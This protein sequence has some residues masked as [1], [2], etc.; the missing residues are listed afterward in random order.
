MADRLT[1]DVDAREVLQALDRLSVA[2]ERALKR[3]AR[4]TADAIARE[5]RARAR[6]ATGRLAEAITVE[7]IASGYRVFVSP[8]QDPAGG[9]RADNFGLWHEH[10]TKFM[11]AQPFLFSSA[12]LEEGTHLRRVAEALQ[13]AIEEASRG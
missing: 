7:E 10:G 8:M 1:V 4:E 2:A 6:R 11:T 12:R 3:A 5:A 9:T 13:D